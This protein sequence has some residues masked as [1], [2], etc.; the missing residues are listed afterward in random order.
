M[1]TLD[2]HNRDTTERWVQNPRDRRV[3]GVEMR[4]RTIRD[5]KYVS[6]FYSGTFLR[7]LVLKYF[8]TSLLGIPS[9]VHE[10]NIVQYLKIMTAIVEFK[11]SDSLRRD[12]RGRHDLYESNT[13][14]GGHDFDGNL[15]K[16][17]KQRTSRWG[18]PLE[19][20]VATFSQDSRQE[21]V[22]ALQLRKQ[23]MEALI[24]Q[25]FKAEHKMRETLTEESSLWDL[26]TSAQESARERFKSSWKIVHDRY[27]S[28]RR[29]VE[30]FSAT[31]DIDIDV[32]AATFVRNILIKLKTAESKLGTLPCSLMSRPWGTGVQL[33]VRL[34]A[35]VPLCDVELRI[36]NRNGS[37]YII[38]T[39]G[40]WSKEGSMVHFNLPHGECIERDSVF[41]VKFVGSSTEEYFCQLAGL[42][43][44]NQTGASFCYGLL[45]D[46]WGHS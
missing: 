20:K 18:P 22:S 40:I 39:A 28:L 3:A 30:L 8:K 45:A 15:E 2:G 44:E 29:D 21:I 31:K 10:P 32:T 41:V 12:K 42:A 35:I 4:V 1:D 9:V 17:K 6:L 38:D 46:G 5:E 34:E 33:T 25:F 11:A 24:E 19:V 16:P 36:K 26:E 14:E 43:K 37:V 23:Q 27:V 7:R 13:L